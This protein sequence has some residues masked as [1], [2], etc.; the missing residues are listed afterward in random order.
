MQKIKLKG[1]ST[2]FCPECQVRK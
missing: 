1:R 2:Y